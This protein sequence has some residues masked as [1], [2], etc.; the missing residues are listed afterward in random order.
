MADRCNKCGG[1]LVLE[2]VPDDEYY[3][4]SVELL[5]KQD[6]RFKGEKYRFI[7]RDCGK[8]GSWVHRDDMPDWTGYVRTREAAIKSARMLF[9]I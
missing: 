9:E 6:Q 7:C 2:T 8:T 3:Q 4:R 5:S 1:E